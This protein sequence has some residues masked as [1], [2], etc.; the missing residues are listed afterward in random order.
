MRIQ[1][2][3]IV[4][5]HHIHL[6]DSSEMTGEASQ[7]TTTT[8]NLMLC[9]PLPMP[10]PTNVDIWTSGALTTYLKINQIRQ[11]VACIPH[12][13]SAAT[14]VTQIAHH[15]LHLSQS[16]LERLTLPEAVPSWEKLGHV[17]A[18]KQ[19]KISAV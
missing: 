2:H 12:R 9:R 6:R 3:R 19:R 11:V 10:L 5:H 16:T 14:G 8:T 17:K 13:I 15:I 7:L 1:T 18:F 4:R